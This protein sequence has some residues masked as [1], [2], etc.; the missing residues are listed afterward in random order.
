[1]SCGETEWGL[2]E[3]GTEHGGKYGDGN[4]EVRLEKVATLCPG[5]DWLLDLCRGGKVKSY[6]HMKGYG[7]LHPI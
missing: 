4:N 1:M 5:L 6:R 2:E 3:T 7:S